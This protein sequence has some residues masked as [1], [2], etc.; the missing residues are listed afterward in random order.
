MQ[1]DCQ[2]RQ[3]VAE[4]ALLQ[5]EVDKKAIRIVHLLRAIDPNA[6]A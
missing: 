4:R 6:A 2:T 5:V 3:A 1:N